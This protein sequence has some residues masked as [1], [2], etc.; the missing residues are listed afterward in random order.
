MGD[1]AVRQQ[2]GRGNRHCRASSQ[3]Q[4]ACSAPDRTSIILKMRMP[5]LLMDGESRRASA[6]VGSPGIY[7]GL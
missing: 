7:N 2:I 5:C 4:A 6:S 1:I 3:F